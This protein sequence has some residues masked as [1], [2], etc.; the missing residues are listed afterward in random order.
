MDDPQP[1]LDLT[2][3][4]NGGR[5]KATEDLPQS[6]PFLGIR[7]ECCRTYGRIY[8]DDSGT[9]Y[10]GACPKC[11]RRVRVPVGPGGSSSRFFS[12]G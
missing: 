11:R 7:F 4:P 9:A 2:N 8:L 5:P 6:K 3:S 12:A 1:S 10:D